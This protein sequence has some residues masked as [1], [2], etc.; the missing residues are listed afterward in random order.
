MKRLY[1]ILILIAVV[2]SAQSLYAQEGNNQ[3]QQ[4]RAPQAS[5]GARQQ[6]TQDKGIPG[7]TVRAQDL[8]ERG[9][10]NTDNAPWVRVIYREVDLTKDE[11]APLYYPTRPMNGQMNLFTIIFQLL[12]EGK[13][14]V[15]KYMDGYEV[16]DE[17][18]K[19]DFKEI[20]NVARIYYEEVPGRAGGQPGFV[21]N[22]SDIPSS[23]ILSYYVKEAWYFDRNNSVFDVKTL[24]ICPRLSTVDDFGAEQTTALFWLPYENIRPYINTA[25]IMTSN[26]NN[27]KTFTI[28]DYFRR[29][30]F[31]GEIIKTENLMNRTMRELYPQPDSLKLAQQAIEAQLTT[32]EESLWF[33]EDTAAVEDSKASGNSPKQATRSARGRVSSVKESAAKPPKAQKAERSAPIRSVRRVR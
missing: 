29:R 12:S 28:D 7:L 1:S 11:N 4:R 20:L 26:T 33:K 13:L 24:A 21:I 2:F 23:D 3:Q 27:A 25:Y 10:Q 15:Y 22:E 31:S 9:I 17:E 30:M 5:R 32:F 18:H 16:F 19:E 8:N 14:T 6:E